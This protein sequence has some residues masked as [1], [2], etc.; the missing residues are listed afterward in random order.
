MTDDPNAV[1]TLA[2]AAMYSSPSILSMLIP[3]VAIVMG[4]GMGMLAL[5]LDYRKKRE[6]YQLHHAERM[7]AIEKG[8]DVPPLP[9]EFFQTNRRFN[10]TPGQRMYRGLLLTLL[11]AVF[12]FAQF[13]PGDHGYWSNGSQTFTGLLLIAAGV[14]NLLFYVLD[15]RRNNS[16]ITDATL[17]GNKDI[18]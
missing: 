7:A 13:I 8:I 18:R 17:P 11:G 6:I 16:A 12:V 2:T 5:W 3:I 15:A 9:P 14:A 1:A 10:A 4:I